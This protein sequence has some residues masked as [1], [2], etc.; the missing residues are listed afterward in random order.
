MSHLIRKTK[1]C[2]TYIWVPKSG[3]ILNRC[4]Y[5]LVI[6]LLYYSRPVL[7]FATDVNAYTLAIILIRI[8]LFFG[9]IWPLKTKLNNFRGDLPN[10]PAKMISLLVG[11][12][13]GWLCIKRT[14]WV[15][16]AE[17]TCCPARWNQAPRRALTHWWTS[18]AIVATS[19]P[20]RQSPTLYRRTW[21][22]PFSVPSC[23]L[24]YAARPQNLFCSRNDG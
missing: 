9:I 13:T 18:G 19:G 12:C 23:H 14:A 11:C 15:G 3:N 20:S 2:V 17:R 1:L 10:L 5:N 4:C 24:Q 6:M 7:S 21:T 22:R 8:F 16:K